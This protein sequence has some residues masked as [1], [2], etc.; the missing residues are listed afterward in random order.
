LR[1]ERRVAGQR[2]IEIRIGRLDQ[3]LEFSQ[4]II[5]QTR[6]LG[7]GEAPEDEVHLTGTAMPAAEQEPLAAI[8]K[9]AARSCRT[10]HFRSSHPTPKARTCRAGLI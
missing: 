9:A 5:A 7:I 8:I 3:P 1:I 4:F 10:R 6:Y 2:G